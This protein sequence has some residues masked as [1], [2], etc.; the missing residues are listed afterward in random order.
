MAVSNGQAQG[1]LTAEM[2][3]S[4]EVISKFAEASEKAAAWRITE[5]DWV[6]YREIMD[7]PRG[8]WTPDAD[9][10]TVLG[11]HAKSTND[12]DRLANAFVKME[13]QR[14]LGEIAFQRAVDAAWRRN[15]PNQERVSASLLKPTDMQPT[16]GFLLSTQ[17]IRYALVVEGGCR[18]CATKLNEYIALME[19]ENGKRVL[20]VFVRKTQGDDAKLRDWVSASGIPIKLIQDR[21]ITVNHG[22]K[23]ALGSVPAVWV[24]RGDGQWTQ[25][26]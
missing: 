26:D 1:A 9:P 8:I 2:R 20:D 22:E 12:R 23:Y 3:T 18:L 25:L 11:A 17:A 21:R 14:V 15:Y 6:R 16:T 5:K 4:A 7:G 19:Q 10:I 24:L 13:Y